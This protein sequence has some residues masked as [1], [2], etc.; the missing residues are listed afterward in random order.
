MGKKKKLPKRNVALWVDFVGVNFDHVVKNLLG[1]PA[2]A[3]TCMGQNP[4]AKIT[5]SDDA[6]IQEDYRTC[7]SSINRIIRKY[8]T[9]EAKY[10]IKQKLDDSMIKTSNYITQF[11]SVV[12]MM[13]TELRNCMFD[14][15]NST[16]RLKLTRFTGF[17]IA[18]ILPIDFA[19]AVSEDFLD[20]SVFIQDFNLLL[21]NTTCT[22]K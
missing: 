15:D 4:F 11:A 19:S 14:V 6:H 13:M 8:Q 3:D 20:S 18:S 21:T 1:N 12:Y 7:S 5:A 9:A 10:I 22:R 16:G 17:N 2:L